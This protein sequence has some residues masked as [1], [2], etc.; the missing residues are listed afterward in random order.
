[1]KDR[2]ATITINRPQVLNAFRALTCDELVQAFREAGYD[3]EVGAIVLTGAGTRAF[4]TGG[5][6]SGHATACMRAGAA[7]S[8]WRWGRCTRRSATPQSP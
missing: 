7:R 1:M 5:D 2:V 4:C 8:A 6:Q 3:R